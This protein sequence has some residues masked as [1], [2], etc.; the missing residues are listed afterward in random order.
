MEIVFLILVVLH[1]VIEFV[2]CRKAYRRDMDN[3]W[4]QMSYLREA[5]NCH[6]MYHHVRRAEDAAGWCKGSIPGSEPGDGGSTPS[7]A[8]MNLEKGG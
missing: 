8:T 5:I 2:L 4:L 1:F 6:E 3:L 7:P